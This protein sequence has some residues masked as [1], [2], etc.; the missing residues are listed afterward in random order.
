[1][2]DVIY[3]N[4]TIFHSPNQ[5]LYYSVSKKTYTTHTTYKYFPYT[6]KKPVV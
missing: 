5:T 2:F 6:A 1:M 3:Y 4:N